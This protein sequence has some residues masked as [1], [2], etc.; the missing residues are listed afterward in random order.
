MTSNPSDDPDRPLLDW[1]L[2]QHPDTPRSRAKQWILAGRV[3]VNGVVLR[4]PH[5][6]LANPGDTLELL[7]RHTASVD[8]GAGWQIHPRVKL[9]YLDSALAVID[10]G[11][12]LVSVP[13]PDG[14][15]SALGI[16]AD[17]LA[18]KLKPR[19]RR[20]AGKPLPPSYRKLQPEPV[21]RLDQYTSGVFCLAMN[22]AA[23]ANLIA[24][25]KDHT[26]ERE[27]IGFVD[28]RV[29]D[30]KGTWRHWLRLSPDQLHQQVVSE[31]DAGA[32]RP[33][34]REAVTHYELL[35]EYPL[36]DGKA[37]VSKLRLR[38]ETGLRHQIRLQAAEAGLPL[39]GDR[40]Y[41]PA[42]RSPTT[43]SQPILFPRQ[44]LHAWRLGLQ[45]PDPAGKRMSW[46]A[47][48]SSDLK[49]LEAAL[50][51]SR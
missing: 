42:Y 26:L 25:V 1:L 18:G 14:R 36:A 34:A 44:A 33:E 30:P 41:H 2:S 13:A 27:Y 49:Q 46:L 20:L 17:F 48:L 4:K 11:P 43:A 6:R 19:D 8:C 40:R 31:P 38:L 9:L 22:P 39:I 10:K 16:L 12:G 29:P 32:A 51:R 5:E 28:G 21:H 23:R 37:F 35:A 7:G 45:H 50:W 47:E 15:L 24:Q 3:R